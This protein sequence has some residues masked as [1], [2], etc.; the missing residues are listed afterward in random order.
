[1]SWAAEIVVGGDDVGEEAVDEEEGA[2][3]S[4]PLSVAA[5]KPAVAVESLSLELSAIEFDD[6]D[7]DAEGTNLEATAAPASASWESLDPGA[8]G[9]TARPFFRWFRRPR[10]SRSCFSSSVCTTVISWIFSGVRWHG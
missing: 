9:S 5:S 2:E 7:G 3:E 10:K 8:L 6:E 1:V 4:P